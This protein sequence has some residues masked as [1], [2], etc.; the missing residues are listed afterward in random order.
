MRCI[1]C[2]SSTVNPVSQN[3]NLSGVPFIYFGTNANFAPTPGFFGADG[4]GDSN[5]MRNEN[6]VPVLFHADWIHIRFRVP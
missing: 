1:C 6:L 5:P 3:K 2:S 4:Q